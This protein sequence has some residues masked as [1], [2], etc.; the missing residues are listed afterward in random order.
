M[1]N[2]SRTAAA[3]SGEI[4]AAR[5]IRVQYLRRQDRD[6]P[7]RQLHPQNGFA[8]KFG[9]LKLDENLSEISLITRDAFEPTL[10]LSVVMHIDYKKAPMIIQRFG[11]VK[12]LVEQTLDPMVSAFSR[13]SRRR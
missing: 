4:H 13:T 9:A 1:A 10:P 7:H 5:Q 6:H 2:S 11:D 3:A 12:K 8:A